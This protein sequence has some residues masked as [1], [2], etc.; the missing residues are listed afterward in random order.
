MAIT[1]NHLP[2]L[3]NEVIDS[4]APHSGGIYIDGTLGG[5]GHSRGILETSSPMG[6]LLAIDKDNQA[7]SAAAENLAEFGNRVIIVQANFSEMAKVTADN[8]INNVDGI[9][10]DLGVS[11]FQLD[12]P[13]RGFS[14][15]QDAQ[16]DMRMNRENELSAY[17]L[18][19]KAGEE[20]LR[21]IIQKYGEERWAAR[22]AKFIVNE[23][24]IAPISTTAELVTVIKKAIPAAAREK[25]QH[26]AKRT[27]QALRIAVNGELDEL[28]EGIAAACN[29][30]KPGGRIAVITFHSLEDRLVKEKFKYMA[31]ECVC[32][33]HIPVCICNH[34]ASLKLINRRPITASTEELA[35]NH[36]SRSAKL[37]VAERL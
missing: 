24:K 6:R 17:I 18:V 22:I 37:R 32:P 12:E 16:L 11:S 14:Y 9:L 27:F 8:G 36:R 4:L 1:F 2:V 31:S 35:A 23:R 28:A 10:L 33:P 25:D 34:H 30:L 20:E 13:S 21:Q 26:P 29:I 15:M 3:Y 19:N 5:G 7:C